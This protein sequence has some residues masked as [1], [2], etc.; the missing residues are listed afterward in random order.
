MAIFPTWFR[1]EN[2]HRK[3]R[4]I[5]SLMYFSMLYRRECLLGLLPSLIIL[6]RTLIHSYSRSKAFWVP[7]AFSEIWTCIFLYMF[8]I[9]QVHVWCITLNSQLLLSLDNMV[10]SCLG[11][12]VFGR[13][14]LPWRLCS[15]HFHSGS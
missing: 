4:A 6:S 13:S 15:F 5:F 11:L 3:M 7:V 9:E 10:S 12:S 14:S 1:V 2:N 8:C